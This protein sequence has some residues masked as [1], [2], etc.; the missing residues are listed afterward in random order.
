MISLRV[1]TLPVL[2]S[3]FRPALRTVAE[4]ELQYTR[5]VDDVGCS[6][7]SSGLAC[8][9]SADLTM[10]QEA[11]VLSALPNVP[12]DPLPLW[13][14]LPIIDGEMVQGQLHKLFDQ[15]KTFKIPVLVGDDTNE[16]SI[17]H[18]M[19]Q[20]CYRCVIYVSVPLS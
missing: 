13:Y 6:N 5:F 17:L 18:K 3:L 7:S 19:P 11:N 15:G 4:M 20:M 2:E 9:Q 8:L 16:G 10:I 12:S 1:R 14:F